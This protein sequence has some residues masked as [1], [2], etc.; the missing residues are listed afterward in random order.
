MKRAAPVASEELPPPCVAQDEHAIRLRLYATK[1]LLFPPLKHAWGLTT[2][3]FA[4]AIGTEGLAQWFDAQNEP[5]EQLLDMSHDADVISFSH[6][7]PFQVR[8]THMASF[9]PFDALFTLLK[10]LQA[11]GA[12]PSAGLN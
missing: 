7:L 12:L 1:R 11:G 8:L 10:C 6:F 9:I 2:N 4:A 3:P 5:V